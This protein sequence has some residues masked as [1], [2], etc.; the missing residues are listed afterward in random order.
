MDPTLAVSDRIRMGAARAQEAALAAAFPDNMALIARAQQMMA[1]SQSMGARSRSDAT[2]NSHSHSYGLLGAGGGGGSGTTSQPTNWSGHHSQSQ[3]HSQPSAGGY[4]PSPRNSLGIGG[5]VPFATVG[6]GSVDEKDANANTDKDRAGPFQ[7]HPLHGAS[8]RSDHGDGIDGPTAPNRRRSTRAPPSPSTAAAAGANEDAVH[9][10]RGDRNNSL[11]PTLRIEGSEGDH[12]VGFVGLR[13]GAGGTTPRRCSCGSPSCASP[14]T[15]ERRR[16]STNTTATN[17]GGP[18]PSCTFI[19]IGAATP[20]SA[21]AADAS[22]DSD[23]FGGQ[24]GGGSGW[25]QRERQQFSVASLLIH[26]PPSD[27]HSASHSGPQPRQQQVAGAGFR[28][29]TSVG[30]LVGNSPLFL[31]P[32]A[33][34]HSPHNS[35]RHH[36]LQQSGA[37]P[38]HHTTGGGDTSAVSYYFASSHLPAAV[39]GD[40]HSSH[41]HLLLAASGAHGVGSSVAMGG[42]PQSHNHDERHKEQLSTNV[43]SFPRS[44]LLLPSPHG[45]QCHTPGSPSIPLNPSAPARNGGSTAADFVMPELGAADVAMRGGGATAGVFPTACCLPQP[46]PFAG[47]SAEAAAAL[48]SATALTMM[49]LLLSTSSP[50]ASATPERP[51]LRGSHVTDASGAAPTPQ[52]QQQHGHEMA[53]PPSSSAPSPTC[54]GLAA[55][56]SPA[57]GGGGGGGPAAVMRSSL[58]TRGPEALAMHGLCVP[59]GSGLRGG[60]MARDDGMREHA[61]SG[62]SLTATDWAGAAPAGSG[63]AYSQLFANGHASPFAAS[64]AS[65]ASPVLGRPIADS[66]AAGAQATTV[67][68]APPAGLYG[69]A[70]IIHRVSAGASLPPAPHSSVVD[71]DALGEYYAREG[72][73]GGEQRKKEQIANSQVVGGPT[74][75][76]TN[77]RG[78]SSSRVGAAALVNATGDVP[79]ESFGAVAVNSDETEADAEG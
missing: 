72:D 19:G 53:A 17:D 14:M 49:P 21:I 2:N 15:D 34:A 47:L 45:P 40:S 13:E 4:S 11:L 27:K 9:A 68:V 25:H 59:T 73:G 41:R 8:I 51:L 65:P 69:R 67:R 70:R 37:G 55:P 60:G 5:L 12:G 38:H 32:A 16:R 18:Q 43:S 61:P 75:T 39:A 1:A 64:A 44:S 42:A 52:Q 23:A 3:S 66:V 78:R 62:L 36:H 63:T 24:G 6:G 54:A 7:S 29:F 56:S 46:P 31:G 48:S 71:L 30:P 74:T 22:P 20:P 26:Q 57:G 50:S 10:A 77:R 33:G 35:A 58:I 76:T 79:W 28:S